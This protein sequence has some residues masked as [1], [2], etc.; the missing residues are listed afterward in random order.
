M[1]VRNSFVLNSLYKDAFSGQWHPTAKNAWIYQTTATNTF[2][3]PCFNFH[4]NYLSQPD[5]LHHPTNT[6]WNAAA[7]DSLLAPFMPVPGS[8]VGVA[9]SS[10]A[11]SQSDTAAYPGIFTARL[12][13]FSSQ[14]VT[15]NWA[16]LGQADVAAHERRQPARTLLVR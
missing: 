4:N 10:Y 12:N 8:N 6:T 16:V 11:P 1:E 7:H 14:P 9:I 2:G 13:T 5:A 15:V 3:H